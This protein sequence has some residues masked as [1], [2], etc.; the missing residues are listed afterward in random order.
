MFVSNVV[1]WKDCSQPHKFWRK[2]CVWNRIWRRVRGN[3]LDWMVLSAWRPWLP[4]S[5]SKRLLHSWKP[6]GTGKT[7]KY[8]QVN[9]NRRYIVGDQR[10][11]TRK[12]WWSKL[13][14]SL[15]KGCWSIRSSPCEVYYPNELRN[16]VNETEVYWWRF[17]NLPLLQK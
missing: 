11:R 8:S 5:S 2:K 3:G 12:F 15:P 6:G 17:W 13:S 1:K 16:F 7:H 4:H 10:F 9:Y 14:I